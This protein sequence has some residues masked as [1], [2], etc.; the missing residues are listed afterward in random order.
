MV[1]NLKQIGFRATT[2]IDSTPPTHN[3][4]DLLVPIYGLIP[5]PINTP[6]WSKT[7][8]DPA[9]LVSNAAML[10][11]KPTRLKNLINLCVGQK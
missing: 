11:T 8:H 7:P 6:G 1:D 3:L 4:V 2:R 10:N 9:G 5:I